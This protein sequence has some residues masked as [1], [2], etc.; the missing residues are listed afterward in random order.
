MNLKIDNTWSLFLD[1]DGVLNE[2]LADDYVKT[3]EQFHFLAGV[4]EA[5]KLLSG[6][7]GHIFIVTNQQG[8][9]KGLM[10]ENDLNHIHN[11]LV[12]E[13]RNAG[14]KIDKIYHSPYLASVNHI[15]RKPAIGMALKAKSDFSEIRFNKSIMVGDSLSDLIFGK[16][17]KMKT[18]LLGDSTLARKSPYFTDYF[19]PDL[20]TFALTFA[21]LDSLKD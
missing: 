5:L 7:F 19:Y 8:I 21:D 18:V 13:V 14:G 9:G 1:R 15:S 4:P 2:R 17:L 11:R 6:V 10:S 16:R 12:T 20:L 3:W